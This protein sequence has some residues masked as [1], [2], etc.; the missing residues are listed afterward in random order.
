LNITTLAVDPAYQN[1]GLGKRLLDQA[2]TIAR[3]EHCTH[4]ILETAHAE[5]FYR[6]HG[7][8]KLNE[9]RQR[10]ITLQVMRLLLR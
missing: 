10:G 1:R 2:I 5:R 6:R 4:I 9:R 8:E 3:R 7:F